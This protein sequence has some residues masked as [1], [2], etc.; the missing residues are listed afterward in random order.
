MQQERQQFV[1]T[2]LGMRDLIKQAV[3]DAM[4]SA[5]LTDE[6]HRWVQLAIRREAQ[7]IAFR[8]KV[9]ESTAIWAIILLAG[10]VLAVVALL[11]HDYAIAHGMWKP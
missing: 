8:D 2:D 6:E 4:S 3:Q 5:L 1:P 7:A 9:I 11:I 10:W